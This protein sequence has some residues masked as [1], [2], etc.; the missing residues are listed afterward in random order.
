M[1]RTKSHKIHYLL[2]FT[3]SIL[4]H[5]LAILGFNVLSTSQPT[6]KIEPTSTQKT[7]IQL[8]IRTL[9]TY[10]QIVEA[11]LSETQLPDAPAYLGRQ[12]HQANK[13]TKLP[14]RKH[15]KGADAKARLS[16]SQPGKK[17]MSQD[18]ANAYVSLLPRDEGSKTGFHDL[19]LDSDIPE[20][21]VL[22]VNTAQF[23]LIGYFTSVRKMVDFA[24]Y[25]PRSSLRKAP[26]IKKQL[27]LNGQVK[28]QG[29]SRAKI[30]VERSGIVTSIDTLDSSGDRELDQ[31]WERILNL[32]APFPPLPSYHS[33]DQL[34]FTYTLY[35]DVI[36]KENIASRRYHF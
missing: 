28:F 10:K 33:G 29:Y 30:T 20:A 11:P 35:Y 3:T 13:Q 36:L 5:G 6:Q 1:I 4:L 7:K 9:P 24:F 22:D 17:G 12:N 31:T 23:K 8:R 26:R 15:S 14:A 21:N 2:P 32:A 18:K 27:V 25:D 19:I 16:T 34:T